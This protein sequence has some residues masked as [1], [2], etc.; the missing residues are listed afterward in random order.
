M[1]ASAL[2]LLRAAITASGLS[3]SIY[4]RTVLIRDPRTLRRWLSGESPI[5][6]SVMD[7]LQKLPTPS[8]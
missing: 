5:P 2:E 3:T 7:F 6:Q 1:S 4:A 8:E